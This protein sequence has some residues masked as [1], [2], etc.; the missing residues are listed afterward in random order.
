VNDGTISFYKQ[1]SQ[2]RSGP[3]FALA[4]DD[5]PPGTTFVVP[6]GEK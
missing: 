2:M 1:L 3:V 4:G 6:E 5:E